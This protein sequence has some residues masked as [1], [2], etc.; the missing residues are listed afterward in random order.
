MDAK[1]D[2]AWNKCYNSGCATKAGDRTLRIDAAREV[3]LTLCPNRFMLKELL[4][5]AEEIWSRPN[6]GIG[7][8]SCRAS[9]DWGQG[10]RVLRI[11]VAIA[12][13]VSY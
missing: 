10:V 6:E 2:T 13:A 8:D 5:W 4:E 11:A 1:Q 12:E 9:H 3:A 7:L